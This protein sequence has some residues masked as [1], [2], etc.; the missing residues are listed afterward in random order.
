MGVLANL[1]NGYDRLKWKMAPQKMTNNRLQ[2]AIGFINSYPETVSLIELAQAEGVGFAFSPQM[3][4]T[5]TAAMLQID[6]KTGQQFIALNPEMDPMQLAFG[7]VHELRHVWQ[8][9]V[10][11]LTPATMARAE[12]DPE[13][14]LILS[15]VREAD[16]AA[17]SKLMVE[18]ITAYHADMQEVQELV[19]KLKEKTGKEPDAFQKQTMDKWL[20]KR[21]A[22]RI[23]DEN[24][25][26][27][28]DFGKVLANIDNYDRVTLRNYHANYTSPNDKQIKQKDT[29]AG[30]PITVSDVRKLLKLGVYDN[31][32]TYLER[33]SDAQFK[34]AVLYDVAPALKK[35]V[36][37]IANFEKA[38]KS[39]KLPAQESQ[40][41]RI[42]I[43][44]TL[45]KALSA[46]A[47][48]PPKSL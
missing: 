36:S 20:E 1:K 26:M 8:N 33:W 46:P 18:R 12:A 32:P 40:R 11:G 17:F 41:Q 4:G 13:T 19:A 14:A 22:D 2:Q 10:L 7:L 27:V 48:E 24:R 37:L 35:T 3:R 23:E 45:A 9:K 38:A 25:Q 29:S 34:D 5:P 30:P 47:P 39:G 31:M 28:L 42:E 16:A 21:F 6:R 43:E 15:R 44:M